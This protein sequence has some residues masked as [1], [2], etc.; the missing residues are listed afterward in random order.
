MDES[1]YWLDIGMLVIITT[2]E[3]WKKRY[4]KLCCFAK[5][6]LSAKSEKLEILKSVSC[7]HDCRV[8]FLNVW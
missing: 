8:L 7:V 2:V 6:K 3:Y 5:F 4:G 1:K